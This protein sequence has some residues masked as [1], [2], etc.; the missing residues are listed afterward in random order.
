M[1]DATRCHWIQSSFSSTNNE[2]YLF[3]TISIL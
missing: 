3:A 1:N 2:A